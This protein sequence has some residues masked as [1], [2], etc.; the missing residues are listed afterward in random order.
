MSCVT[1]F[2][3]ALCAAAVLLL[4]PGIL[5]ADGDLPK[6]GAGPDLPKIDGLSAPAPDKLGSDNQV[7]TLNLCVP[8]SAAG[9]EASGS[10]LFLQ[11][12][13]SNLVYATVINPYPLATPRWENEAVSPNFTPAFAIGLGYN[14][15]CGAD[16]QVDWTHLNT[17]DHAATFSTSPPVPQPPPPPLTGQ[18]SSTQALGPSFLLIGP[19]P[20]FARAFAD[21]HFE[22]DAINL[23]GGLFLCVGSHLQLRSFAGLQIAHISESLT[24]RFLSVNSAFAFTDVPQSVFTGI[25]PR[26]GMD[27]NYV[28]GRCDFLGEIAGATLIGTR[29]SRIDFATDSFQ[30]GNL[31]NLQALGSPDAT[32]VI[33]CIDAKLGA[34]Y[35]IPVGKFGVLKCEAG[36][37]AAVY[38]SAINQYSLSGVEDG[39]T[40]TMEGTQS[41]FLRTALEVQSN[42]VV[43]GPYVKFAFHF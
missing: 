14:F 10:L 12:S 15:G 19:P 7:I 27:V 8:K 34:S 11:P 20:P 1:R 25:G 31:P 23:D 26:L 24:T 3:R 16:V 42:F 17:Y 21:A 22:Y 39:A 29:Q 6:A 35:A 36:Y 9:F 28:N 41:V 32:Q 5:R 40:A 4:V 37:Q 43:H 13:T 38:I 18:P 2:I 33:P 30:T